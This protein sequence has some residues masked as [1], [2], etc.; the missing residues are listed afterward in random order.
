MSSR[1]TSPSTRHI[2]VLRI[3]SGGSAGL[4]MMIALLRLA[5]PIALSAAAVV[6]VNSSMFGAGPR[7]RRRA[8]DRRD[9]LA[10]VDRR[11]AVD[12]GHHRGRRLA[13]AGGQAHIRGAAGVLEVDGR[14]HRWP[15]LGRRQ[16]DREQ[17]L[18]VRSA[19]RSRCA[20][21]RS[22]TRTRRRA[23]RPRRGRPRRRRWTSGRRP[24]SLERCPAS[25]GRS[26]RTGAPPGARRRLAF[27]SRSVPM[28]PVPR[29]ATRRRR[30]SSEAARA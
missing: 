24:P 20:R 2:T 17:T 7:P 12:G 11:H 21:R 3:R 9:D 26:P 19:V 30:I 25:P 28:L 6:R 4:R 13:A 5:P 8:G 10:V 15:E 1:S 18:P 23:R 27:L 22:C 29:I 14:D 16:V